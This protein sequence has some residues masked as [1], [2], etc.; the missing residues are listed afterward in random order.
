MSHLYLHL[1]QS[2]GPAIH[3][4]TTRNHPTSEALY[5]LQKLPTHRLRQCI[6][7][8]REHQ[9]TG[10]VRG[11][12]RSG[13]AQRAA[14]SGGP[15]GIV[16][17][18]PQQG[19]AW[20]SIWGACKRSARTQGAVGGPSPRVG[21]PAPPVRA[22]QPPC[23][24]GIARRATNGPRVFESTHVRGIADVQQI[25]AAVSGFNAPGAKRS[26]VLVR[27]THPLS[28]YDRRGIGSCLRDQRGRPGICKCNVRRNCAH[29]ASEGADPMIAIRASA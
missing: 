16:R 13:A 12:R 9:G 25:D 21:A 19:S 4:Q 11:R 24:Q 6:V 27:C 29:A 5:R 22:R 17:R 28:A 14:S 15:P 2:P 3:R 8:Y 1:L 7:S 23:S 10:A 26:Q 18:Q 20:K